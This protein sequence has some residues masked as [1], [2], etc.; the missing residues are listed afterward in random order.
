MA[1]D[2]PKE[3]ALRLLGQQRRLLAEQIKRLTADMDAIS[4][5]EEIL[6]AQSSGTVTVSV[7]TIQETGYENLQPQEA[8]LKL[9]SEKPDKAW[10][11]PEIRMALN[12]QGFR[13]TSKNFPNIL[14]SV[15]YRLVEKGEI[16][17]TELNGQ[18]YFKKK[19]KVAA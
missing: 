4:R 18:V 9:I 19:Q 17:K 12:N 5:A 13:A 10:R 16:E 8:T 6:S 15:L 11:A 2:N 7:E 14:Y 3:Q 1:A